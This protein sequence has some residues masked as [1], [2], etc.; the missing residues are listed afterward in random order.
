MQEIDPGRFLSSEKGIISINNKTASSKYLYTPYELTDLPD[1]RLHRRK[2]AQADSTLNARGLFGERTYRFSSLGNLVS[3]FT[4]LGAKVYQTLTAGNNTRDGARM[5]SVPTEA[6]RA[7]TIPLF[8]RKDT[9][10]PAPLK[11]P[12]PAGAWRWRKP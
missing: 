3:D 1:G 10:L 11:K 4:T 2:N 9:A 6:R 8:I 7:I 12:V 5:P